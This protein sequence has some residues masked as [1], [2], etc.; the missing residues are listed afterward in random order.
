[1]MC[2][3][4]RLVISFTWSSG[5]CGQQTAE[6]S[7]KKESDEKT[8]RKLIV[9]LGDNSFEKREAADKS[10]FEL[11]RPA[12]PWLRKAVTDASDLEARERAAKLVRTLSAGPGPGILL[13]GASVGEIAIGKD[14]QTMA[15]ACANKIVSVYD[16]K[17]MAL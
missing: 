1:M 3:V 15:F 12:L 8:I 10:L 13:P 2:V 9:D 14:G 5:A 17:T 11:G 4:L 7:R 16:L 6:N